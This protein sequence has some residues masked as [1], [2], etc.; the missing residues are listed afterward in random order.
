MSLPLLAG[1][2]SAQDR[3]MASF[4]DWQLRCE[5]APAR[6]CEIAGVANTAQGRP[7]AQL[8]VGRLG[9]QGQQV[10]AAVLPLGVHLPGQVRLALDGE[11][12]RL[13]FQRC[14]AEGCIA[15]A[16]LTEPV[17]R[18]LRAEPATA[19]LI[20]QDQARSEI[21][22]TLSLRGFARAHAALLESAGG[23]RR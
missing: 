1:T 4:S 19:R 21:T 8:L 3:T 13:E 10:V 22:L 11:P 14:V 12:L 17:L 7:A 18:S 5:Q 9:Q 16:P 15:S 2:A 6:Q 20:L 23:Q